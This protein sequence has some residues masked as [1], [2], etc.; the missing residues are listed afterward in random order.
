VTEVPPASTS[1]MLGDAADITSSTI[2]V[3]PLMPCMEREDRCGHATHAATTADSGTRLH[4]LSL[5]VRRC[6]SGGAVCGEGVSSWVVVFGEDA[7]S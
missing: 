1:L 6:S 4:W 5:S 3:M 7:C 2:C